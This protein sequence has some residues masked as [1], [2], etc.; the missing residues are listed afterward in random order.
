M[1]PLQLKDCS[2]C[3]ILK[4]TK[5]PFEK[6][7]TN[8][9]Y[10]YEQISK[11]FPNENYGV[12]TGI[13]G[14]GV[15]DDDSK[16]LKLISLLEKTFGESFR[17]R[18]HYY[19]NFLNWS[20]EKIIFFDN[21]GEH[22][23]ELQGLGQQVVGAGSLHP[24]GEYYEIIKDVPIITIDFEIFKIL[25]NDFIPKP[26]EIVE[27]II[28]KT[29]W[30]GDDVKNIPISSVISFNGMIDL[31]NGKYQGSHPLHGSTTG[32]NF[33]VDTFSNTWHCFRCGSGGSSPELIAVMEGI[34]N[35]S[36]AGRG[37][38]AG[39]KGSELIK[40]AR[41]KYGLKT[42]ERMKNT[43][44]MGWACSINIKKF[45][46]RNNI[47]KCPDCSNSFTFD[48][49]FGLFYCNTCKTKGTIKNLANLILLNSSATKMPKNYKFV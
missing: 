32:M 16:D 20:G 15:C 43:K 34:I 31:K 12:L 3:R 40:I 22:L 6:D 27:R 42:P 21:H 24:S 23:G 2:F 26:K 35:C 49:K 10:S 39:S 8:K 7:W 48:E 11:F 19:I 1:I 46:E 36:D 18:K 37:C 30:E 29:R 47:L 28:S 9:K 41:E 14:I 44:P 33:V 17:V 13:N 25:M 4:G 38:L 45:A 5:K